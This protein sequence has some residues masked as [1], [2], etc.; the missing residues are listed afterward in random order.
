MPEVGDGVATTYQSSLENALTAL[1]VRVLTAERNGKFVPVGQTRPPKGHTAVLDLWIDRVS[2]QASP[3][4]PV[5]REEFPKLYEARKRKVYQ[6]AVESLRL[7][8]LRPRDSRIKAFLKYEKQLGGPTKAPRVIMPPDPRFLVETGRYIHP[9]EHLIYRAIDRVFGFPVVTKGLNY[10]GV[11]NIFHSHWCAISDPVAFDIDVEK[12]DRS[13]SAELLALTHRLILCYFAGADLDEITDLLRRQL[14]N[15]GSVKVDDGVVTYK[16]D[17]TLTSG[18]MNTSLAGITAVCGILW[19]FMESLGVDYRYVDA[20]DD[21]TVIISRKDIPRFLA[22]LRPAFRQHGFELTV[23]PERR[24]LEEIEFCQTHPIWFPGG[25]RMVR[26][27]KDAARKDST[28]LTPEPSKTA[29]AQWLYA[30][31]ESGLA[32]HGGVP[33]LQELYQSYSRVSENWRKELNLTP[34]AARRFEQSARRRL[35]EGS[36]KWYGAG[37]HHK[38]TEIHPLTRFS[39]YLA[40][41]ISPAAQYA[42]EDHYRGLNFTWATGRGERYERVRWPI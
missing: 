23:S 20:G 29:A 24:R 25:Y 28:W 17:G 6:A 18:Q 19:T 12:M 32:T 14:V 13:F 34:R 7:N 16:V 37:L 30:V 3:T 38:Y 31:S 8:P 10:E 27:A 5:P 36:M 22:G 11:G 35:E 40:F 9:V 42:L 15:Q 2:S 4:N 41:G 39:F 33:V 21:C 1:S 26:N